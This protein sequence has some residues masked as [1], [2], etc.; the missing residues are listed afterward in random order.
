MPGAY[1]HLTMVFSLA[2]R[3]NLDP[4]GLTPEAVGAVLRYRK[5]CE[6]GAVSPDYPY[7]DFTRPQ[8]TAWAD[9]MHSLRIGDRLRAGAVHAASLTGQEREK[10][11]AWL[12]GF[13]SHVV[14]DVTIH[15]VVNLAVGGEYA[16][17]KT[18]H[19][20]CEMNQDV[21][22]YDALDVGDIGEASELLNTGMGTCTD[23]ADPGRIDPAVRETWEIMLAVDDGGSGDVM[24]FEAWHEHFVERLSSIAHAGYHMAPWARHLA[25]DFTI[26]YPDQQTL[27]RSFIDALETPNPP[28]VRQDYDHIFERARQNVGRYWAILSHA[29][30]TDAV[31]GMDAFRNWNL[32]TGE[33]ELNNLTMWG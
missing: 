32:D 24:A 26:A 13:T 33:D 30:A 23:P 29:V 3:Q 6:F 22:I 18:E 20:V 28:G 14:T 19:R 31:T 2:T 25:S 17:H 27:N 15:P 21:F 9:R 10:V 5:F 8:S 1:A 12:L 7:L 16:T 11:L 4:F